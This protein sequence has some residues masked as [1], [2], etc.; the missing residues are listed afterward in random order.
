MNMNIRLHVLIFLAAV[1]LLV[2]CGP[3]KLQSKS[4][5][6]AAETA[7]ASIDESFKRQIEGLPDGKVSIPDEYRLLYLDL[8]E[9][10]KAFDQKMDRRCTAPAREITFSAELLSANCHAGEKLFDQIYYQSILKWLDAFKAMGISGVKIAV[11][12]PVLMP[13]FPASD[14]YLKVYENIVDE[15]RARGFKVLIACGNFFGPPFTDINYTLKGITLDDYRQG[16][17]KMVEKILHELRP[18]YLSIANEPTTEFMLTGV[19]QTPS[20]YAET[21]RFILNGL[22]P[23]GTL[24]GCGTGTWS[25]MSYISELA[26]LREL[27]YIDMHIY[28]VDYLQGAIDAAD[29][30]RNYDKRLVLAEVGLYKIKPEEL[31]TAGKLGTQAKIFKRDVYSFWEPLDSYFLKLVVKIAR[32]CGYEFISPFWSTY[33]FSYVDYDEYTGNLNYT[34]LRRLDN[35]RAYSNMLSGKLSE[36]GETYRR[37][38]AGEN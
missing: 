38:I 31:V 2:G 9:K 16:K 3:A 19:Y 37:L 29:I 17:K 7:T 13:D 24:M 14:N 36:W 11:D 6:G 30:A 26:K 8:E 34:A 10:L 35:R 27:D 12:Y 1:V 28:P 4:Y 15:C 33:L 18:D 25:D 20:Q 23:N 21:A 32:C 5:P 22:N